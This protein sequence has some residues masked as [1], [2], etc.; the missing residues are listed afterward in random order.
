M[1]SF[2]FVRL[3]IIPS[4]SRIK[5]S[6]KETFIVALMFTWVFVQALRNYG[7]SKFWCVWYNRLSMRPNSEKK[8]LLKYWCVRCNRLSICP[9]FKGECLCSLAFYLSIHSLLGMCIPIRI[10]IFLFC[11]CRDLV[12]SSYFCNSLINPSLSSLYTVVLLMIYNNYNSKFCDQKL[13]SLQ[14]YLSDVHHTWYTSSWSNLLR[15]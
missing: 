7:C 1:N 10:S 14:I 8:Q 3:K 9:S 15:Y 13:Y 2:I 11:L 5:D 4:F 12:F 6:N